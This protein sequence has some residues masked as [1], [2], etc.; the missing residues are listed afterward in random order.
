M[1]LSNREKLELLETA[2]L[3]LRGR[4]FQLLN[5]HN[6]DKNFGIFIAGTKLV[7]EI[8]P[9]IN[10]YFYRLKYPD[11]ANFSIYR[12]ARQNWKDAKQT[13]SNWLLAIQK[14][15]SEE[16]RIITDINSNTPPLLVN[17][18]ESPA[19]ADSL[20]NR[21]ESALEDGDLEFAITLIAQHL[22]NV[23]KDE[24]RSLKEMWRL[25]EE[26]ASINNKVMDGAI[27]SADATNLRNLLKSEI[28]RI[29]RII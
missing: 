16:E 2:N 17:F 11:A 20:E 4:N 5:Q 1:S 24:I 29:A 25:Q 15:L 22:W 8:S 14:H 18:A 6:H 10:T 3:Y 7:F 21:T 19:W 27:S 9:S 13:F 28:R 23:E 26:R 12:E